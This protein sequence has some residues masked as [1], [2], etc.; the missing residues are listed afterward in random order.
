MRIDWT[1]GRFV[2]Q[3]A[4]NLFP[5]RLVSAPFQFKRAKDYFELRRS[6]TAARRRLFMLCFCRTCHDALTTPLWFALKTTH[7][8][9]QT[10]LLS[11]TSSCSGRK[12]A[13]QAKDDSRL[14]NHAFG[15]DFQGLPRSQKTNTTY[16]SL[17]CE[18]P[19]PI[20]NWKLTNHLPKRV[21][22]LSPDH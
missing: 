18:L 16:L 21:Y 9:I 5:I 15:S 10:D 20:S 11:H 4:S 17:E 14:R 19:D 1:N 3:S 2:I 13:I 12:E 22:G 7:F 8:A 6:K